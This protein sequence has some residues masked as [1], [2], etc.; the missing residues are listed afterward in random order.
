MEKEQFRK[1]SSYQNLTQA[2]KRLGYS[3]RYIARN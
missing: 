1:Q 3:E 2:K